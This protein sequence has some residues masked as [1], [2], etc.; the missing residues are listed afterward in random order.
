MK[1]S[2]VAKNYSNPLSLESLEQRIALDASGIRP[3]LELTT[4]VYL[5][6]LVVGPEP[7]IFIESKLAAQ[8]TEIFLVGAVATGSTVEKWDAAANQWIDVSTPPTST[9]L[10]ELSELAYHRVIQKDT[11]LRW[12]PDTPDQVS[13]RTFEILGLGGNSNPSEPNVSLPGAVETLTINIVGNEVH[14]T[15]DAPTSGGAVTNYGIHQ[16]PTIL[17][18]ASE[19]SLAFAKA[20][21]PAAYAVT[22]HAISAEGAGEA[23]TVRLAHASY[24]KSD[25]TV[26]DPI[27]T[28]SGGRVELRRQQSWTFREPCRCRPH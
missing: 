27:M 20:V 10:S 12:T 28:V 24:L 13:P 3:Q 18:S 17:Q 21:S 9:S 1:K 2:Q 5:G 23:T 19:T 4:K 16:N 7:I 11:Q 15:W 14:V 8:D 6:D 22:V 26:V 25:G